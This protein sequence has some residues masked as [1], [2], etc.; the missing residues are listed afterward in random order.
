MLPKDVMS[1]LESWV[2]KGKDLVFEIRPKRT[3]KGL[4]HTIAKDR[5]ALMD[6]PRWLIGK[7]LK[8][9]TIE[10]ELP[11]MCFSATRWLEKQ[12]T[13][14]SRLF[15]FGSGGSTLFWSARAG[16]VISVEHDAGW[17]EKV[18]MTLD[19][20]RQNIDYRLVD[21]DGS[22]DSSAYA[23][24]IE[25]EEDGSLDFVVVDGIFRVECLRAA[26][27]KVKPGGFL[28]LDNSQRKEYAEGIEELSAYPKWEFEGITPTTVM[29]PRTTVWKIT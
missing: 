21:V 5:D 11:W 19:E 24:S 4:W 17:Y 9:S 20:K 26:L 3:L 10:A 2:D 7:S 18:K 25:N 12:M 15:E 13:S 27:P 8:T 23:K 1:N 22:A 29:L 14:D 6:V 28:I 16:H